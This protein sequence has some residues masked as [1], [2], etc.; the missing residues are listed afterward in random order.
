MQLSTYPLICQVLSKTIT[1]SLQSKK[2]IYFDDEYVQCVTLVRV[3]MGMI[4]N[5]LIFSQEKMVLQLT[6]TLD[7]LFR[8]VTQVLY[9]GDWKEVTKMKY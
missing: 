8:K 4:S 3:L 2:I 6:C 7:Y 1:S 5:T 9:Y